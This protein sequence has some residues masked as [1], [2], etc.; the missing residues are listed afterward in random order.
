M[1][2]TKVSEWDVVADN[3]QDISGI[4]LGTGMP[5]SYVNDSIREMMAQLKVWQSGASGDDYTINGT[6]TSNGNTAIN[7]NLTINGDSGTSGQFLTSSGAGSDPRWTTLNSFKTGMIMIWYGSAGAVP[8]GW[9]ICDGSNGTPN[10]R[11]KF[12]MGANLASDVNT[13]GG[14]ATSSLPEHSHTGSTNSTGGHT[15]STLAGYTGRYGAGANKHGITSSQLRD[16]IQ[17]QVSV[18]GSHTHTVTINKAGK[19]PTNGNLPPYLALYYI[20]KL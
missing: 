15:H 5:P 6:L 14:S 13:T 16:G 2:K 18:A 11:N 4:T 3:N 20:M 7:G 19:N 1:A 8:S 17:D 9:A 12:V 10:L